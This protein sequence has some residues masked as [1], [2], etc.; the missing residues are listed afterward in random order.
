MKR[1][2]DS[3]NG[4]LMRLGTVV[5][6]AFWTMASS[7]DSRGLRAGTHRMAS[8]CGFAGPAGTLPRLC[9]GDVVSR[10]TYPVCEKGLAF[11]SNSSLSLLVNHERPRADTYGFARRS[12]KSG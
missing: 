9:R 10:T 7:R 1:G 12:P 8:W 5:V 11:P 2:G 6:P 4:G 3:K